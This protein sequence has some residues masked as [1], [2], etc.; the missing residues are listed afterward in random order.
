MFDQWHDTCSDTHP[1]FK[2]RWKTYYQACGLLA[3]GWNGCMAVN[4]LL[5]GGFQGLYYKSEGW[6]HAWFVWRPVVSTTARLLHTCKEHQTKQKDELRWGHFVV[7]KII[8]SISLGT[9]Y[10]WV[11]IIP[12]SNKYCR[13]HWP[14]TH[15]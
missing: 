8:A 9:K 13:L 12:H 14:T 11:K 10:R 6:L 2:G 3:A 7:E 15:Q 1:F 4:L 5:D